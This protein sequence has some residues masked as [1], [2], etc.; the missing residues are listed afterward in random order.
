MEPVPSCF[1]GSV[2]RPPQHWLPRA[3]FLVAEVGALGYVQ[4]IRPQRNR[5][6]RIAM[7]PMLIRSPSIAIACAHPAPPPSKPC[8]FGIIGSMPLGLTRVGNALRRHQARNA[9]AA[10]WA[11]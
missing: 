6:G 5:Q 1:V 8:R 10:D 3:S 2:A 4:S 7:M 11:N 9:D